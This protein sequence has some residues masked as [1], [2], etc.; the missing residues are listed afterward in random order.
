MINIFNFDSAYE[1][2]Q[3]LLNKDYQWIDLQSIPNTNLLCEKPTLQTIAEKIHPYRNNKINLIGSG[4]YHYLTYLL[5]S[6]LTNP[7]TLVLF[8]HHTDTLNSPSNELISCGSWVQEALKKLSN[9]KRVL[10]IG[11]SEEGEEHI[12]SSIEGKVHLYPKHSLR[13]NFKQA[14]GSILK[15]IR[16]EEVYFSIDKDVLDTK[17]AITTWDHGTM[18]LRHVLYIIKEIM[19][20]KKISGIDICGEYPIRPYNEF[21]KQSIE[22]NKKN[23]S[24]NH[25][26]LHYLS[27]WLK[28][29]N[30][31]VDALHA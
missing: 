29:T 1:K 4:N 21:E 15:N 6:K 27:K 17:D 5:L 7:F 3:S 28:Q 2:Q 9:L 10:I 24:A 11:V 25:F 31:S 13:L 23:N 14:L 26:L 18:R 22:A 30:N 20:E 12:S 19:Q 8:D 16:T